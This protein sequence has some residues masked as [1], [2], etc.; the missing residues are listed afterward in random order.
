MLLLLPDLHLTEASH[1]FLQLS[2]DALVLLVHSETWHTELI[3]DNFCERIRQ[4]GVSL[5]HLGED[6]SPLSQLVRRLSL[7][8]KQI[9]LQVEIVC[10]CWSS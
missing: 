4:V 3:I 6:L 2:E 5:G 8:Q 1:L 7:L 9:I 10:L